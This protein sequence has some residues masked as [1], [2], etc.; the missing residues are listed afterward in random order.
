MQRDAGSE[1]GRYFLGELLPHAWMGR[2][3]LPLVPLPPLRAQVVHADDVAAAVVEILH[4]RATGAFNLAADPPVTAADVARALHA[5]R[6]LPVPWALAR[7]AAALT[8]RVRLQPTSEGWVD[9][10][11]EVPVMSTARARAELDWRPRVPAPEAITELVRGIG[12]GAG[13]ASPAMAPRH[14]SRRESGYPAGHAPEA[15]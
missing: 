6:Y 1:I 12:D 7:A 5:A 13:A 4:R 9:L 2:L 3:P 8:W 15:T 14:A 10:G 11:R